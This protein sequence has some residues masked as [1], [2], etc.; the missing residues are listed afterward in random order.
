MRFEFFQNLSVQNRIFITFSVITVLYVSNII[1]NMS[2]LETIKNNVDSIYNNRM[3][4]INSLLEADRDSYQSRMEIAESIIALNS[5][6]YIDQSDLAVKIGEMNE[7][8]GQV[9]A[10]FT[11]FKNDY[12]STGGVEIPAF[13]TFESYLVRVKNHTH[14]IENLI[15]QQQADQLK[16]VYFSSY[17]P[18]YEIMRN[19]IDEMTE[20]SYKQTEIEYRSSLEK[21]DGITNSTVIFF[22][23]VLLILI[24]SGLVLTRNITGQLGCEPFE[25]AQIA[26]SLSKGDLNFHFSKKHERGLYRDLKIMVNKLKEVLENVIVVTGNLTRASGELSTVSQSVSQSAS[27]QAASAEELS[28]AM[29]EM[30]S[31]IELNVTNARETENI[32]IKAADDVNEGNEAVAKTISSMNSIAERIN[33][34]GEI[35][36]QTNILALNAAVEAARAGENGKGFAVVASEVRSLAEKS[37]VAAEEID[38]LTKS[39][40]SIAEDSG[41]LFSQIV[42]NIKKTSDLVQEIVKSS[43]EQNESSQQVNNALQQLNQLVQRNA[44]SA[45]EMASNSEELTAQAESLKDLISFFSFNTTDVDGNVQSS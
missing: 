26:K 33:I 39:S 8:L 27:E 34:I 14:N 6:T 23:G 24:V 41:Q 21:A 7:N 37:Q 44:A 13:E 45:E 1:Y 20:E 36:K 5:D 31:S 28:A 2:S 29:E 32:G 16:Q 10:R 43:I 35:V 22:M 30:S 11:K 17:I 12:L 3:L 15:S 42:P 40:V 19:A 4:S 18:D 38:E 25:A 9:E